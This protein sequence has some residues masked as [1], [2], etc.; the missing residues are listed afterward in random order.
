MRPPARVVSPIVPN[1]YLNLGWEHDERYHDAM[2][3]ITVDAVIAAWD[4][5]MTD[6]SEP[7]DRNDSLRRRFGRY[8]ASR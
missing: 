2:S 7:A 5:L 8:E 6:G 4:D 1:G 3:A